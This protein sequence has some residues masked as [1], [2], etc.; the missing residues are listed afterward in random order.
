[1]CWKHN[2]YDGFHYICSFREVVISGVNFE[3]LGVILIV[4]WRP[5]AH[6]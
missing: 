1:M 3:A 6:F 5:G 2:K 4:F